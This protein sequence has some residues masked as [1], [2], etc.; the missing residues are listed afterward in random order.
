MAIGY[1]DA[2]VGI[3]KPNLM[4]MSCQH[5]NRSLMGHWACYSF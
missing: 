5:Y 1:K 2:C 4:D 3:V